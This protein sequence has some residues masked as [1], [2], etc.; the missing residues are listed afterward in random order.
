MIY[1]FL[2]HKF[3]VLL[4]ESFEWNIKKVRHPGWFFPESYTFTIL[5]T[6]LA[7]LAR[8][9]TRW[10]VDQQIKAELINQNQAGELALLRSQVNPHFLFNTLNNIYS[11]VYSKSEHAPEA[12]TKLSDIMRYMLYE[13]NTDKVSLAKEAD[14]LKSYIELLQLRVADKNFIEFTVTGITGDKLIAPMLLIPFVENAYK[15]CYRKSAP[16]GI[17]ISLNVEKELLTFRVI[18]SYKKDTS[19]DETQDG[20]I[21]L[22]NVKRR[23]EML[24]PDHHALN[25]TEN[26]HFYT[27]VLTIH[28]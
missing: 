5:Y 4:M 8:F 15:H 24:Y 25:I 1:P 3:F 19:A 7:Y 14:Y 22:K 26:L 17:R 23:L 13:A 10:V 6:G 9:T 20:G 11:L 21:G 2:Q 12:M 28:L 27:V 18:N 16:P